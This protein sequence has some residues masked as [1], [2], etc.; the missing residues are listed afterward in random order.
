ME[1]GTFSA[2]LSS[3]GLAT[4]FVKS[5]IDKIKDNAVREKVQELLNAIIPLQFQIM[6][7]QAVN[8]A[9]T[10]EKEDLEEELSKIK[11]WRTE[12]SRYELKEIASGVYAYMKKTEH[13]TEPAH[14]L[15]TR[16]YTEGKKSIL[17][18]TEKDFGG[19]HYL[20]F[21]CKSEII[22]HSKA[23]DLGDFA[24]S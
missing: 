13:S 12:A 9:L 24:D 11:D 17:Q 2:T 5:S 23:L 15:C 20:C 14:Y 7:L 10:K 16:C 4:D 3:I 8:S 1:I 22:D 21:C 6:S 19:V 18:R